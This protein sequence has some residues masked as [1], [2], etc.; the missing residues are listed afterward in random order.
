LGNKKFYI[1]YTWENT[2]IVTGKDAA[3]V[4]VAAAAAGGAAVGKFNFSIGAELADSTAP[5]DICPP[6]LLMTKV[7]GAV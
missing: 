4:G 6:L 2:I 3:G 1:A 7:G 5:I